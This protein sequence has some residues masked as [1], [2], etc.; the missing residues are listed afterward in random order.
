M[1]GR[2]TIDKSADGAIEGD[3]ALGKSIEVASQQQQQE[4]EAVVPQLQ[5]PSLQ[6]FPAQAASYAYEQRQARLE[7]HVDSPS[8]RQESDRSAENLT[9]KAPVQEQSREV[10]RN[11][12]DTLK[13]LAKVDD[14][15]HEK[16]GHIAELQVR[17][18]E[19][20][21]KVVSLEKE[22]SKEAEEKVQTEIQLNEVKDKL[23][24][25]E[26]ESTSKITELTNLLEQKEDENK[27]LTTDKADKEKQIDE[28][29]KQQ[30]TEK[31]LL[32][33]K[34]ANMNTQ[35][36][37]ELMA[38]KNEQHVLELKVK[39]HEITRLKL[40]AELAKAR[41][42]TSE[43]KVLLAAEKRAQSEEKHEKTKEDHEKTKEEHEKTKEELAKCKEERDERRRSSE[44]NKEELRKLRTQVSSVSE[45]QQ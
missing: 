23:K 45:D 32:Q 10:P 13:S 26:S 16:D 35:H 21:A 33:S 31:A 5:P 11:I 28:L 42:E 27:K 41:Q 2:K 17:V 24:K 39:D 19:L 14:D 36:L 34:I 1:A 25:A 29:K 12:R 38:V 9:T 6:H 40:T 7:T 37:R 18:D 22:L 43:I 30:E 3:S 44:F 4:S 15:L 20:E 8:L